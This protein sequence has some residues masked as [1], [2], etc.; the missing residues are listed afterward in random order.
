MA[1]FDDRPE[2]GVGSMV[3]QDGTDGPGFLRSFL[4][5]RRFLVAHGIYS[6]LAA[7]SLLG[8][9]L[10]RFEFEVPSGQVDGALIALPFL[11]AA[12]FG[13]N[14]GWG[15]SRARWRFVGTP[16]VVRLVGAVIT[17]SIVF[18]LVV[19]S[20]PFAPQVPRSIL[21]IEA[22]LTTLATA[23]IWVTYRLAFEES[24]RSRNL[25]G[26]APRRV[27]LVGAGE[28]GSL[29]AREMV[30]G[31]HGYRVVGF[32]DDDPLKRGTRIQGIEVVGSPDDLAEI[33][34]LLKADEV[35]VAI[36]S[37]GPDAL[38][39][40]VVRCQGIDLP[41]KVLP[42]IGAVLDGDV[43]PGRIRELRI[44]D[45]LGR[46]PVSLALPELRADVGGK[47]VLVTGAA[48]SIGSELARQIAVNHPGQLI[49]LDVAE[50]ALFFLEREIREEHPDLPVRTLVG[51]ILDR[52]LV[53]GLFGA[54]G[55]DRVYHAAA[56]KHVPLMQTNV[57]AAVMNNVLGTWRLADAAGRHGTEKFVL[58]STDK[59]V[60]PVSVMGMTKHLAELVVTSCQERFSG[61]DFRAVRFG[62]VLGSA[63]SVVP[64][65]QRQLREGKPLTVTH[66]DVSRYFMTIPEAVHLVLQA[67]I[68]PGA[69]GKVA[70]LDMGQPVRILDLARNMIR[71][72]GRRPDA[73]VPIVFT[74]LRP[75]EKMHEELSSPDEET[76]ATPVDK[77][78]LIAPRDGFLR[79]PLAEV[80]SAIV[81]EVEDWGH[82][83]VPGGPEE[84]RE[85]LTRFYQELTGH[86]R[87]GEST[88]VVTVMF[89]DRAP[90]LEPAPGRGRPERK[91]ASA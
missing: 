32:V 49:L 39:R 21:L 34:P 9:Y 29:L 22:A 70:M 65:F 43:G 13:A 28:A 38:R 63:G 18:A 15:L 2:Q 60:R 40:I 58:I 83:G 69:A 47:T 57:R 76:E 20:L 11:L 16:E 53:E 61:T 67:S 5:R 36:P 51:N 26:A 71:L 89:S 52:S 79:R 54:H 25:D 3:S 42:G 35:I 41:F 66:P 50:S 4:D 14:W 82:N 30:R 56:F 1:I 85:R 74:G 6:V 68:L 10:L 77:V 48:G 62:N 46:D 17:G 87:P 73:D 31:D 27:I 33:A 90:S 88:P 59:A 86:V 24:K 19:H 84:R 7:G 80:L 81:L 64:I 55:I 78:L 8:A 72:F 37:A 12:R 44:D 45:L 23:G 91:G 75:G